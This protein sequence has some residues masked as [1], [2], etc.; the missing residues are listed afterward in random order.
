MKAR[1]PRQLGVAGAAARAALR[2]VRE[3]GRAV[4]GKW[5][6]GTSDAIA[7]NHV[8]EA[9]VKSGFA[10]T[11]GREWRNDC[12]GIFAEVRVQSWR[13]VEINCG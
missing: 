12:V 13:N 5:G 4:G 11:A 1:A 8:E 6:E 3:L 9:M 2:R 10:S 7:G